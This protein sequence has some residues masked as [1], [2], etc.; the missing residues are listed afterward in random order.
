MKPTIDR[1]INNARAEAVPQ[2]NKI[3]AIIEVSK[4]MMTSRYE[5]EQVWEQMNRRG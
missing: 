3:T 2:E 4:L 1:N 5:R